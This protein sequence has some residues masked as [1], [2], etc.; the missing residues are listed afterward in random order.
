[1]RINNEDLKPS[2]YLRN[3]LSGLVEHPQKFDVSPEELVELH[4][5]ATTI[6]KILHR[7]KPV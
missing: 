2:L 7:V 3:L 1:M 6:N 4:A 5:A